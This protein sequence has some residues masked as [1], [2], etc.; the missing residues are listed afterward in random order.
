MMTT[1]RDGARRR[2]HELLLT[3]R[4]PDAEVTVRLVGA[5]VEEGALLDA[6]LAYLSVRGLFAEG[7]PGQAGALGAAVLTATGPR[8]RDVGRERRQAMVRAWVEEGLAPHA[9]TAAGARSLGELLVAE[10]LIRN[11]SG[12]D[13]WGLW[14]LELLLAAPRGGREA[15]GLGTDAVECAEEAAVA[16]NRTRELAERVL[17]GSRSDRAKSRIVRRLWQRSQSAWETDDAR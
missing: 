3:G 9:A 12:R 1:T 6:G 2:T 16:L 10:R 7:T 14:A 11:R 4:P 15:A 13:A 8:T 5:F 17:S